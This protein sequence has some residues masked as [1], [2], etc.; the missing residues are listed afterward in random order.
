MG[1]S[2]RALQG[3]L[4]VGEYRGVEG[5]EYPKLCVMTAREGRDPFLRKL[6]FR[7]LFDPRTGEPT[8]FSEALRDAKEGDLVA[9]LVYLDAAIS[10]KGE[11]FPKMSALSL[12]V[13]NDL[14]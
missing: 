12:D 10:K 2:L 11:A 8:R 14:A 3:T 1:T 7:G 9:V 4:V 6:D 5:G 13:V